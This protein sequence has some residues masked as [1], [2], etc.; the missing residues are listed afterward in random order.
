MTSALDTTTPYFTVE[1]DFKYDIDSEA[2][3]TEEF[4]D[5]VAGHLAQLGA[6]DIMIVLDG[7]SRCFSLSLLV[8][9][10]EHESIETVVGKGMGL[11]R[12]A[13][14]ACDARTPRWPSMDKALRSMLVTP[15]D[16]RGG[17]LA[18]MNGQVLSTV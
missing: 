3:P 10:R 4:F 13:F 6:E 15:V 14:H 8:A 11:M 7:D 9:S 5:A 1:A 2:I 12:T 18:V 16:I 17:D